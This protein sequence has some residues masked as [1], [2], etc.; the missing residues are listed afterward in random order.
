MPTIT[1]HQ[2]IERTP[3]GDGTDYVRLRFILDNGEVLDD[4]VRFI[5]SGADIPALAAVIG[6]Q[7]LEAAAQQE[8][9]GLLV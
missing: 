2:I 7:L 1:T 9:Q 3:R 5:Q 4:G 6:P 8:I